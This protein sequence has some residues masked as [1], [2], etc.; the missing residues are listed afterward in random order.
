[1]VPSVA[2]H[3]NKK[4]DYLSFFV[5][6]NPNRANKKYP[7]IKARI[8]LFDHNILKN[9]KV[10]ITALDGASSISKKLKLLKIRYYN[11]VA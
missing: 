2:Y 9:K 4:L 5:D 10:L 6:D 11:P 8:K 7:F 3:L 1:M